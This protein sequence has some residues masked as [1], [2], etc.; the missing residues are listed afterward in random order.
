MRDREDI[1]TQLVTEGT[2][3]IQTMKIRWTDLSKLK[4]TAL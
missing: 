4:G 3:L 1:V 2:K